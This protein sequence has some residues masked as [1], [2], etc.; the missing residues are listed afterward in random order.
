MPAALSN[1]ATA[2]G[3]APLRSKRRIPKGIRSA[4]RTQRLASYLFFVFLYKQ[5]TTN[6][7]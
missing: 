2:L 4:P 6:N 1:F 3:Y 5:R 7:K